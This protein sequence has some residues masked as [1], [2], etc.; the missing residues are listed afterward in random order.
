MTGKAWGERVGA[1]EALRGMRRFVAT[2][3]GSSQTL[4]TLSRRSGSM[5]AFTTF[6]G[7]WTTTGL[8]SADHQE[9]LDLMTS[10]PMVFTRALSF[11]DVE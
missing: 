10:D 8:P 4:T 11:G 5:A 9:A 3:S 7:S 1:D 2:A 6:L